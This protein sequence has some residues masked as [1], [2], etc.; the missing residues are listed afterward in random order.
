MSSAVAQPQAVDDPYAGVA[1]LATY[2]VA[3]IPDLDV[4]ANPTD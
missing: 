2:S 4:S 3:T 1:L